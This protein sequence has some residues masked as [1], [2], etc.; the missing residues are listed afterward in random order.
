MG[1]YR[2]EIKKS[3]VKEISSLPHRDLR[4]ILDKIGALSDNP[5]PHDVKKLSA[6]EKYRVRCGCYRIIYSI[7]DVILIV[8]IVKVAHRKDVYR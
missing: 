3:A 2:V 7:E 6:Q 1:K 5:R 4:N 8:N